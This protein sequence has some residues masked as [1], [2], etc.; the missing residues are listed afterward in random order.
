VC[1]HTRT[2]PGVKGEKISR[3]EEEGGKEGGGEN[4]KIRHTHTHTKRIA[5]R[6]RA[7]K[8]KV[9]EKRSLAKKKTPLDEENERR[10]TRKE[11]DRNSRVVSEEKE[12]VVD[13][14][15]TKNPEGK[16]NNVDCRQP[17]LPFLVLSRS[18]LLLLLL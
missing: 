8:E 2:R 15:L 4:K 1:Y 11:T 6:E 7:G 16:I 3:S 12:V 13:S 18:P 10:R 14:L 17:V 9:K 5:R